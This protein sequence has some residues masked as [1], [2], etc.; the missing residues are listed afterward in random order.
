MFVYKFFTNQV[1][2]VSIDEY[3][4]SNRV[5]NKKFYDWLSDWLKAN[6]DKKKYKD[7]VAYLKGYLKIRY[8][9]E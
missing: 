6:K 4:N 8:P 7:T 5:S 1:V 2:R 9:G 3:I